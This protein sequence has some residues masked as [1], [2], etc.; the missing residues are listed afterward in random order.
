MLKFLYAEI[1]NVGQT[2][3]WYMSYEVVHATK[4]ED[5]L[6]YICEFK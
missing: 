3:Q 2:L 5:S 4:S 1:A 6:R